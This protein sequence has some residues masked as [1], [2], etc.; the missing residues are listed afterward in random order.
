MKVRPPTVAGLFYPSDPHRLREQIH[1][2]LAGASPP[3]PGRPK[4]LIAP[5]AGYVFS[6]P[7]AASGLA[8]LV[9]W[10]A[11][12]ERVVLLGTC[13]TPGVSGLATSSDQ[14]FETPLGNVL[15]DRAAVDQCLQLPQVHIHDGA[16]R[17]DHALEV[18]LPFLQVVL[19]NFVIVPFLVGRAD[20]D[21]VAEVL[22]TLWDGDA[23][24]AGV[25]R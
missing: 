16:Q 8:W 18:Q 2:Y 9:P 4:A 7:V 1:G 13:H 6:G 19:G 10:S 15:V 11:T 3:G 24:L 14:A 25:K 23:T 5:H 21:E 20:Q 22:E 17:S 12:I